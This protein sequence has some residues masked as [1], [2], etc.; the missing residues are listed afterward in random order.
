MF[1]RTTLAALAVAVLAAGAVA[2]C[3]GS[4]EPSKLTDPHQII[5]QS[6]TSTSGMKSVHI[7]MAL[8]GT[9]KLDS[10]S[11]LTG[12][13]GSL[14]MSSIKL[15]NTVIEGDADLKNPSSPAVHLAVSVPSFLGLTA[16]VIMVDGYT[17]TKTSM[18]GDKYTK[19]KSTS[20]VPEAS[21]LP[22]GSQ[23]IK[24]MTDEL[25]KQLDDAGIRPQL[26][27]IEKVDGNDA[28][29]VNLPLPL[30]K[31]NAGIASAA[32]ANPSMGLP[33]DMKLDSATLDVWSYVKD[34]R[35]AKMELKGTSATLGNLTLTLTLSKYN[36]KVTIKAPPADQ[37][38]SE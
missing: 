34:N 22:T 21:A 27:G 11:G 29:H 3:S 1:R 14:G 20:V 9:V 28:Y 10:L 25:K 38:T 32:S 19:S 31:I 37:V 4:A 8:D 5:T 6:L 36:E 15:D 12:G 18:T 2:G 26:K 7:R 17:Y 23:T 13:A 24:Q 33:S 35:L 30:D 16:D